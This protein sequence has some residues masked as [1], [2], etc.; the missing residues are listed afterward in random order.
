MMDLINSLFELFA[1]FFVLNNCRVLYKQKEVK[2][3][4]IIST[5]F[6]TS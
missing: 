2:G 1:S 5:A 6:F 3:V 4:S